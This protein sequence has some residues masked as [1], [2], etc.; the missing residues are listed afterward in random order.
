MNRNTEDLQQMLVKEKSRYNEISKDLE[1]YRQKLDHKERHSKSQ[2]KE[3]EKIYNDIQNQ[4]EEFKNEIKLLN[5]ENSELRMRPNGQENAYGR[6][7]LLEGISKRD[8]EIQLLWET[9]ERYITDKYMLLEIRNK[10]DKAIINRGSSF[11]L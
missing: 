6:K 10:I 1:E 4:M 8:Y 9:M 3:W 5:E 11:N 2:K 7:E